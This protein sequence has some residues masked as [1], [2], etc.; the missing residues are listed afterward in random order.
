M[1]NSVFPTLIRADQV[2]AESNLGWDATIAV[3]DTGLWKHD[4]LAN[5]YSGGA[6]VDAV[7]DAITDSWPKINQ[8]VD[9]NGHGSHVA[10]VA[11]SSL[12]TNEGLYNGIAPG[13]GIFSIV[14]FDDQGNGTYADVIRGI[15]VAVQN[16]GWIR[17]LNLSIG[18]SV[19]SHY[20]DDPLNQAVMQAWEAGLVVVTSAGNT[21][22]DPQTVAV[23]ANIPYVITVGAMTDSET[24]ADIN[25]DRLTTFSSVG[26]TYEGFVKPEILAPGGHMLGLMTLGC[27]VARD[28]SGV[29]RR[30][31]VLHHVRHLPGSRRGQRRRGTDAD[32]GPQPHPRRRQMPAAGFGAP[33]RQCRR[34]AGL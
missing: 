22:P 20:W 28:L 26:P 2:H 33:L 34:T 8:T 21:G 24:P 14:A 12:V 10:S 18:A 27:N 16:V 1:L 5:D 23:P 13:A 31:G 11:A 30:R 3:L 7:Y 15:D 17:V 19:Q 4:G 9:Q 6:R 25:D 32:G 29:P